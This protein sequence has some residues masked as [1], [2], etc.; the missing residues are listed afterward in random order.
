[1]DVADTHQVFLDLLQGFVG[2]LGQ[3]H[4]RAPNAQQIR[5]QLLLV[6]V[7]LRDEAIGWV[8]GVLGLLEW[9]VLRQVDYER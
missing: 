1:M 7:V 6:A 8:E 4:A 5:D 3:P 2:D 9:V